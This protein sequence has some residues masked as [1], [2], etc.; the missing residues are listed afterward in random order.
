MRKQ[1]KVTKKELDEIALSEYRI[2]IFIEWRKGKMTICR[3]IHKAR[4]ARE[5]EQ[6]IQFFI[7][8][9]DPTGWLDAKNLDGEDAAKVI[10]DTYEISKVSKFLNDNYLKLFESNWELFLSMIRK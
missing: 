10:Y 5:N 6:T 3:F 8:K 1:I 9:L 4:K 7:W 2:N